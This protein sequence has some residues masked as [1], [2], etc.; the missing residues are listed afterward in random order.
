[1]PQEAVGACCQELCDENVAMQQAVCKDR[2]NT[3]LGY[4]TRR[5]HA[6]LTVWSV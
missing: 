6:L 3:E 2:F 5:I 1:M 4:Q